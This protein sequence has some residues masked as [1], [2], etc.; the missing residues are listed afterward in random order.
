[1]NIWDCDSKW[2]V[3]WF[4][5]GQNKGMMEQ[6]YELSPIHAAELKAKYAQ[7]GKE[8]KDYRLTKKAIH[9]YAAKP[10]AGAKEITV[11]ITSRFGKVWKETIQLGN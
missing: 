1:M 3:E 8:P 4:E 5:D 2:K 7:T 6:V 11:I 10:S 9:F